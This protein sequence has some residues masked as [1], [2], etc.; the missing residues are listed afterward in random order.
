MLMK[1]LSHTG[2]GNSEHYIAGNWTTEFQ[3]Q[4]LE[5]I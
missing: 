3:F 2:L 4:F 1:V 5:D